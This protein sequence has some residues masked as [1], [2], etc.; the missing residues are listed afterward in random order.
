PADGYL[1][2]VERALRL[3]ATVEQVHDA[4][5]VD[6]WFIAAIAELTGLRAQIMDAPVVDEPLLRRAQNAGL[7]DR[8]VAALRLELAGEDGVR[9]LRR[10]LG[11][12]PVYKT[13]DTSAGEFE[14]QTAYHYSSYE[15]DPEAETEVVEQRDK[16]K[17]LI[18]GSGPNR[19]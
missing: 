6:P 11:V 8:Q 16:P 18:L 10:R 19:I 17:V 12:H 1:Y 4:S 7:S 5:G 14:A 9:E 15:C 2:D 13:V 3:G